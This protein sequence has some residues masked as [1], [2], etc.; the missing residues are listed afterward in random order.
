MLAR[1]SAVTH[2]LQ[3]WQLRLENGVVPTHCDYEENEPLFKILSVQLPKPAQ[4]VQRIV[5]ECQRAV[6]NI[7]SKIQEDFEDVS[8]VL[9]QLE[10]IQSGADENSIP[11]IAAEDHNTAAG[12]TP[13]NPVSVQGD[14]SPNPGGQILDEVHPPVPVII[15]TKYPDEIPLCS[16]YVPLQN[17]AFGRQLTVPHHLAVNQIHPPMKASPVLLSAVRGWSWQAGH[18]EADLIPISEQEGRGFCS[19]FP[20][21][22]SRLR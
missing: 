1:L 13:S 6:K 5:S 7:Q 11:V 12:I 19:K 10:Q 8:T 15:V 20:V 17:S 4:T 14:S 18:W 22:R 9:Y 21:K 2:I 16:S 3:D